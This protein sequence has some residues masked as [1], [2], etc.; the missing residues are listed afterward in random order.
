MSKIYFARQ[1]HLAPIE[2][3]ST[4]SKAYSEGEY[5]MYNDGFYKVIADI[6]SGDTLTAGTNI[7]ATDVATQLKNGGGGGGSL[8]LSRLYIDTPPTKTAYKAGETFDPT[9]M[10]V[11]AD[12]ALGGVT[13]VEGNVVSGY[14]YPT[15]ALAA[16]TN[17]V[18]ITYSEGG[19]SLTATQAI[20]VTKTDVTVPTFNQTLTFIS[21]PPRSCSVD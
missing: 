4:A 7:E 14:A 21:F 5:L 17:S 3:G 20:S 18:A 19:V 13:I 16:G 1:A 15:G 9:G 12:Y 10:V 11:K 2:T 6:A 8:T